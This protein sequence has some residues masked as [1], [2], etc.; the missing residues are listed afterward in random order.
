MNISIKAGVLLGSVFVAAAMPA[1]AND[2]ILQNRQEYGSERMRFRRETL[3]SPALRNFLHA[4]SMSEVAVSATAEPAAAARIPQLGR[5]G[6]AFGIEASSFQNI[7]ANSAVWGEASYRNGRKYDV[8]WNETSDFLLLYPYVMG[9]AK[10]GDLDSE[11]YRL[12][13]GY[14]ARCGR[15]CYGVNL[16]YRALSE[17]RDRDP[18]PGN[19]V[20]DLYARVALG[21]GIRGNYSIALTATAGKY[22]Q[23]NELAFYNELGAQMVYHLTGIGNDFTRFSGQ[24]SNCFYKGYNLGAEISLASRDIVGWSASAGYMFTQKEKVLTDFNRLPLNRL[25]IN[26]LSAAVGYGSWSWGGRLSGSIAGRRGVD[27]IFGDATGNVYPQIGSRKQYDGKL[28]EIKAGG[29]WTAGLSGKASVSIEPEMAYASFCSSH[30]TSGNKF[31]SNDLYVGTSAGIVYGDSKKMFCAKAEI[32][33]RENLAASLD[34]H[35]SVNEQLS[36]TLQ[37]INRYMGEG[38]TEFGVGLEYSFRIWN[39]K[40]ITT[41]TAWKHTAYHNGSSNC[42]EVKLALSL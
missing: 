11:E 21:Y 9:D 7:G 6:R 26:T 27:N 19:T 13:G 20:A 40:A 1:S 23:T 35:S 34:I 32:R 31:D 42:Y 39:D 4:P 25:E 24:G 18:R 38:E 22:K 28:A 30:Y 41:A 29:Y 5:G 10:G 37:D 33:R 2:S 3:A 36:A 14:S 12:D 8:A 16:G 15:V 17:Y